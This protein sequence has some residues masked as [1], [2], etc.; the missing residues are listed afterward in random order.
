LL[1]VNTKSS[2]YEA[3]CQEIMMPRTRAGPDS[4]QLTSQLAFHFAGKG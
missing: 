2:R 1:F 4:E 3:E